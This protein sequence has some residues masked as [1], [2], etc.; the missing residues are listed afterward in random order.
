MVTTSAR[1]AVLAACSFC[2]KPD[3][4]VA[5]IVAGPGVYICSECVTL[6]QQAIDEKITA[7]PQLLP[8]QQIQ[9][10]DAVLANL[11]RVARA[12][13]Q[14]EEALTGWVRRGR[15]LGATW[16][17]IGDALGMTRQSAWTRFSGEE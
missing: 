13:A 10:V 1:P 4:E 7:L 16:A 12:G 15:E 8:W 17:R 5:A 3:T 11:P 14:V 2:A 9:E 6:A